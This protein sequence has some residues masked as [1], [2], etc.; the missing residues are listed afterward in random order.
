M[1]S[2]N[3]AAVTDEPLEGASGLVSRIFENFHEKETH[4]S[5][6]EKANYD[7]YCDKAGNHQA[8]KQVRKSFEEGIAEYFWVLLCCVGKRPSDERTK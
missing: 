2:N 5:Q 8:G 7:R 3:L 1:K 6:A 4:F